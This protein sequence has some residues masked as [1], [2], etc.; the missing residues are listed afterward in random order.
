MVNRLGIKQTYID[1]NERANQS[2]SHILFIN[3]PEYKLFIKVNGDV[4][5]RYYLQL[6]LFI[7][8]QILHVLL[9][10]FNDIL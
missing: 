9:K 5:F 2:E 3:A 6:V 4:N 7:Y 1:I 10:I 8:I